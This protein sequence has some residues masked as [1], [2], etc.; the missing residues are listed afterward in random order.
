MNLV[1]SSLPLFGQLFS[2]FF[3]Y[4]FKD[5]Q[6]W[7]FLAHF[8][9]PLN[10]WHTPNNS[11]LVQIFSCDSHSPNGTIIGALNKLFS[12]FSKIRSK[13]S[14]LLYFGAFWGP[15]GAPS[16]SWGVPRSSP[17]VEK[18]IYSPHPSFPFWPSQTNQHLDYEPPLGSPMRTEI[19]KKIEKI[20]KERFVIFSKFCFPIFSY[21]SWW[22]R[23][24][25]R[26]S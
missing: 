1:Q 5:L 18:S 6:F 4:F 15:T 2:F 25:P 8:W 10:P 23:G 14:L 22:R 11:P 9:P 21:L 20:E 7:P 19:L 3:S 17:K 13:F 24:V 26:A 16:L 12:G